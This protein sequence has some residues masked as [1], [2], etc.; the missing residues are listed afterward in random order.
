[1]S[2]SPESC[3]GHKPGK[4]QAPLRLAD[5]VAV[6]LGEEP[7][8]ASFGAPVLEA[9][10][11]LSGRES[12]STPSV[13]L[14]RLRHLVLPLPHRTACFKAPGLSSP[15]GLSRRGPPGTAP[16]ASSSACVSVSND[17]QDPQ[18]GAPRGRRFTREQ[19]KAGRI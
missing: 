9:L 13:I 18:R 12:S 2:S 14:D 4:V 11:R 15:E 3:S 19:R 10:P 7:R 8:P 5:S 16:A 17:H 6:S 1:M